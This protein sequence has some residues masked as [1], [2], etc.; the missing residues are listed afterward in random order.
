MRNEKTCARFFPTCRCC[1][2]DAGRRYQPVHVGASQASRVNLFERPVNK[3]SRPDRPGRSV[4]RAPASSRQAQLRACIIRFGWWAGRV[5]GRRRAPANL[6]PSSGEC[7]AFR[8][9]ARS[10]DVA[11]LMQS[12]PAGSRDYP[13]LVEK[14]RKAARSIKLLVSGPRLKFSALPDRRVPRDP[15]KSP[16]PAARRPSRSARPM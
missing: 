9:D 7:R 1:Q 12:S 13:S 8:F 2:V 14:R 5:A 4:R 11:R 15:L 3:S 10:R 16:A 6:C